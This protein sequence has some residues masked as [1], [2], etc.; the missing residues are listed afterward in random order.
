MV[1]SSSNFGA[2]NS[3]SNPPPFSMG[4]LNNAASNIEL[5]IPASKDV[6]LESLTSITRPILQ[7]PT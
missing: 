2:F 4:V 1:A 3:L 7:I 6:L 5:L